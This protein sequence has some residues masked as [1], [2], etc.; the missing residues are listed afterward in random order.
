MKIAETEAQR[1][2]LG[3][4]G[5]N[6]C[7]DSRDEVSEGVKNQSNTEN[8]HDF[9]LIVRQPQWRDVIEVQAGPQV[10][11]ARALSVPFTGR[12]CTT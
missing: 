10:Q 7:R 2:L 11:T 9:L 8:R 6:E 1:S 12:C 4:D 3:A 5:G